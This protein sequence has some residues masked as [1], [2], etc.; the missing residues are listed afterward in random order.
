[1]QVLGIL[2]YER[3]F[4]ARDFGS[5]VAVALSILPVLAVI[6]WALASFMTSGT[7][8]SAASHGERDPLPVRVFRPGPWPFKML[9]VLLFDAVE[10]IGFGIGAALR[11][12]R[13]GGEDTLTGARTSR[14]ILGALTWLA[15]VLL[16]TFELFPF[17]FA[18]VSAF[19]PER[20]IL[21]MQSVLLPQPWTLAH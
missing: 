9:F 13:G 18:F 8:A 12:L 21:S 7:R 10:W 2:T 5:G 6:I 15:L 17:Y 20:Q 14:R 1:T 16:L 19:K 3:G 4:N 11:R